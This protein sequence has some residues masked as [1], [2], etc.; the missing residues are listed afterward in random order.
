MARSRKW[1]PLGCG[2]EGKLLHSHIRRNLLFCS[3]GL[4]LICCGDKSGTA[5]GKQGDTP[6]A[7]SFRIAYN[8]HLPDSTNPDNYEI[9][10]MD[11]DGSHRKNLTR[12]PDVAWAYLSEGGRIY[13]LSDRDTTGRHLFLYCMNADG[14]RVRRISGFQMQDSWMGARKGGAE[15]IVCPHPSVDSVLYL[16]DSTGNLIRKVP[17]QVRFASDPAFSPDGNRIAFRGK[18]KASKKEPGYEEAIY[19][20]RLDGSGHTRV[21]KYPENDTTAEWYAYKAGPPRWHPTSNFISYQSKRN[22]KYSLYAALPDGSREWKLT[23]NPQEE[24][25]HDWSPDGNYLA[26][27]LFDAGQSR[28]QI[29]LMDW[30]TG[31]MKVLADSTFA[32]QQAPVFVTMD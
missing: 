7:P 6:K 3:L 9:F 27:E 11:M 20:S 13:F 17:T 32:Y 15:L 4:L 30:R 22:G 10:S 23:E 31:E 21:S 19:V 12:N 25:W 14:S 28:F 2:F 8:V 26:I 5:R 24:G 18:N 29:G 16:I 1:R